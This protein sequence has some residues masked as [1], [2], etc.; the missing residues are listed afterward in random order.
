M[1]GN[2]KW[3]TSLRPHTGG[4]VT[5]GNKSRGEII[6]IGK[7]KLNDKIRISDVSLVE[8]ISY[9]LL[10]VSQLCQNGKNRVLFTADE[11]YVECI[12]IGTTLLREKR[13]RKIY[14]VDPSFIP[15]TALCL[16]TKME[17]TGLWHKRFG[18][19]SVRLISKLHLM[20]LVNG[21]P[22]VESELEGMCD[23]CVKGKQVRSSFKSKTEVSSTRLLELIHM[24]LCGPM[25][26]RPLRFN[27]YVFVIV[28]DYSRYTWTIFITSQEEVFA[29]FEIW[30]NVVERKLNIS[31]SSMRTDHGMEFDNSQ[32][33]CLCRSK[34]INYNFSAPRTPQQNG[35]VERKN[36]TLKDMTRTLLFAS[37]LPR[38]F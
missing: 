22:Q 21:L 14:I 35:F 31:L 25:R 4:P 24:D 17:E 38:S 10:S 7:V 19:A 32:F 1:T 30:M 6:G 27:R 34:G 16:A 2:T 23:A 26:T 18:H 5:F 12:S 36:I 9:D 15:E 8:G 11:C 13:T 29:E 3:Y 33:L 20:D 28:D 37:G